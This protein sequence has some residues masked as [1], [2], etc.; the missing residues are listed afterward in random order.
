[1][2]MADAALADRTVTLDGKPLS[3]RQVWI[4]SFKTDSSSLPGGTGEVTVGSDRG[5]V[6]LAFEK[7]ELLSST[8]LREDGTRVVTRRVGKDLLIEHLRGNS[9][10][11][12]VPPVGKTYARVLVNEL[13]DYKLTDETRLDL[14]QRLLTDANVKPTAVERDNGLASLKTQAVFG[15][16]ASRF[17]FAEYLAITGPIAGDKASPYRQAALDS[18]ARL[19]VGADSATVDP[20]AQALLRDLDEKDSAF[21]M[22]SVMKVFD[23]H[24][25]HVALW[26][27]R[28]RRAIADGEQ[29]Y[30]GFAKSPPP[31]MP[32]DVKLAEQTMSELVRLNKQGRSPEA[33]AIMLH[34][35]LV[36]GPTLADNA[37]SKEMQKALT[38]ILADLKGQSLPA[39]DP[40]RAALLEVLAAPSNH[41]K[42]KMDV[43]DAILANKDPQEKLRWNA[44]ASCADMLT[45]KDRESAKR[46]RDLILALPVNKDAVNRVQ[47]IFTEK[48]GSTGDKEIDRFYF[49]TFVDFNKNMG[50]Q[51]NDPMQALLLVELKRLSPEANPVNSPAALDERL[52]EAEARGG[53]SGR[54][55]FEKYLNQ[56]SK[57]HGEDD[58]ELARARVKYVDFMIRKPDPAPYSRDGA[59][60]IRQCEAAIKSLQKHVP[61]SKELA[62]VL[63]TTAKLYSVPG[64]DTD[65]EKAERH[66]KKAVEI[67]GGKDGDKTK[68]RECLGELGLNQALNRKVDDALKTVNVLMSMLEGADVRTQADILSKGF[69]ILNP[70]LGPYGK[71]KNSAEIAKQLLDATSKLDLDKLSQAELRKLASPLW[72]VARQMDQNEASKESLPYFDK[73][74]QIIDKAKGLSNS[75]R[76]SALLGYYALCVVKKHDPVRAKAIEDSLPALRDEKR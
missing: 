38:P 16:Q 1:M 4:D 18:L 20:K 27:E 53:Y 41:D 14:A 11:Q 66:L 72:W 8:E 33:E 3:L 40:R 51:A 34:A 10:I 45:S 17:K 24:V 30:P 47:R 13:S 22:N 9:L 26:H 44:I 57:D 28:A 36:S 75:D 65:L 31:V 67:Y 52:K 76:Y 12:A 55:D 35:Y 21:A 25:A 2:F 70:S 54:M 58:L 62:D 50:I 64:Y 42:L 49:Q 46:A 68:H 74:L 61:N 15:T 7:G 37:T 6:K 48:M 29:K 73:A 63:Q 19:A 59:E 69:A 5:Q 71:G 60:R 32:L 43:A 23:A 39:D 56:R